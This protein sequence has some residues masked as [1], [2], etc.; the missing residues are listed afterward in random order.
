MH[1]VF[2][3]HSVKTLRSLPYPGYCGYSAAVNMKA[4]KSYLYTEKGRSDR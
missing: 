1:Y 4:I 2:F 3:I